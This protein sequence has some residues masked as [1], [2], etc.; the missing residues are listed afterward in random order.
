MLDI[1][2]RTPLTIVPAWVQDIQE[3]NPYH[4]QEKSEANMADSFTN[5]ALSSLMSIPITR[6]P[7]GNRSDSVFGC[8]ELQLGNGN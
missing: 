2:L 6:A 3:L 1:V 5:L 4:H 8:G 7:L